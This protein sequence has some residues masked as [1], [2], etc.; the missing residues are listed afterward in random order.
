MEQAF[1]PVYGT[2]KNVC[3]TV[4]TRLG[5]FRRHFLIRQQALDVR[6]MAQINQD[7]GDNGEHQ[8]RRARL[9]ARRLAE[10]S[11]DEQRRAG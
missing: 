6:N 7:G 10:K 1:L 4:I 5:F 11:D 9:E 2:D 3:P 8:R